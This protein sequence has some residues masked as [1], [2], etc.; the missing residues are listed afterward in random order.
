MKVVLSDALH[1]QTISVVKT[2]SD[3]LGMEVVVCDVN[4][5]DFTQRD[6]AGV[7]VQ[8]PDTFG[9][10]N[11]FSALADDAH[12]NGVSKYHHGLQYLLWKIFLKF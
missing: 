11:D 1:P 2:R 7:L 4:K 12:A 9:N 10:V 6:I 8:Y 5:T 3:A